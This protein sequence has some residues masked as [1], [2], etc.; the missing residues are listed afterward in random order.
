MQLRL[1][2]WV[3][4]SLLISI[5]AYA[6]EAESAALPEP[7]TLEYALSLATEDHPS[8]LNAKYQLDSQIARRQQAEAAD[9]FSAS[10]TGRARW[11]DVPLYTPSPGVNDDHAVGITL[12]KPL[13]DSGFS[14]SQ[15]KA[16]SFYEEGARFNYRSAVQ[17]RRELIMR[18]YLDVLLADL[19]FF[20]ENEHMASAY[21]RLDRAQKRQ[22]MGQ[23]EDLEILKLEREYQKVRRDRYYFEGQQRVTRASLAEAMNRPGM[24]PSTLNKPSLTALERKIPEVDFLQSWARQNNPQL[25]ALRKELSGRTAAVQAAHAKDGLR[26][27]V[28]LSYNSYTFQ[29]S[30]RENWRAGINFSY[31]LSLD[32]R[33]DADTALALS[34]KYLAQSRLQEAEN[35]LDQAVLEAWMQLGS[36]RIERQEMQALNDYAGFYLDRIRTIY[37]QGLQ[38]TLG[39][40]MIRITD[41]EWRLA[42]T[43]Y[44][45]AMLWLKLEGMVG[46]AFNQFPQTENK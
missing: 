14:T 28:E 21:I 40:A 5:S 25:Q 1:W 31:P 37:E 26:M 35:R 12:T 15:Q 3:L 6:S 42:R 30:G 19:Q 20:R 33:S 17:Q 41:A 2:L 18:R 10:L 46:L 8:L 34:Q 16:A 13:L 9:D 44:E 7:L 23:G 43:E 32:G 24:L 4:P 45:M 38:T 11:I 36:L 39:D 29:P 27:D 22:K